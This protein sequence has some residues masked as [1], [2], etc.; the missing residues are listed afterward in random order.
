LIIP[1]GD[2]TD[3]KKEIDDLHAHNQQA[4]STI[5][6]LYLDKQRYVVILAM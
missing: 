1:I 5:E 6:E 2:V 3:L 4:E